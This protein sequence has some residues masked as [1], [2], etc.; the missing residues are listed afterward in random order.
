V[1]EE[2]GETDADDGGEP[3]RRAAEAAADDAVN[4]D[5]LLAGE[6]PNTRHLDDIEHWISAYSELIAYKETL[7]A[8]TQEEAG[9]MVNP[10]AFRETER[11]DLTI[12]KRELSNFRQRLKFWLGR[13]EELSP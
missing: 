2:A 6:D 4:S 12:L 9:T 10:A 11:V 7:I 3:S 5:H 13:R 1:A 8:K